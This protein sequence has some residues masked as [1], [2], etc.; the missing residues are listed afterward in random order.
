MLLKLKPK[1]VFSEINGGTVLSVTYKDRKGETTNVT[2]KVA[3]PDSLPQKEDFY[4]N[5]GIHKAILLSRYA[6]LLK[7]WLTEERTNRPPTRINQVVLILVDSNYTL[8]EFILLL[9]WYSF[10]YRTLYLK[11]Y[12]LLNY[13]GRFFQNFL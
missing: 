9:D 13:L 4:E 7:Y 8:S 2:Q 10:R 3:L 5:T 11:K 12:S 6:M 1:S